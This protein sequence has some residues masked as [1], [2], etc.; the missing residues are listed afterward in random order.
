[1]NSK[2]KTFTCFE[3]GAITGT[4]HEIISGNLFRQISIKHHVQIP[5][6]QIC[7]NQAHHGINKRNMKDKYLTYL[8][9][10][11]DIIQAYTIQ[12]KRSMLADGMAYRLEQLERLEL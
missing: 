1:M 12:E 7:H 6:C 2:N 9:L 8:G 3:C 4:L 5:L 10:G 11:D